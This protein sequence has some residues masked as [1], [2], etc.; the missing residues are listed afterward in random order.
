MSDWDASAAEWDQDLAA[1]QYSRAAFASLQEVLAGAQLTLQGAGVI[2]FGCG[3]GLLTEQLVEAGAERVIAVDTSPAM[4]AVLDAKVLDRG[5]TGVA[6]SSGLPD[7]DIGC[8]LIVCS[9]VC[10]FLDDYPGA[11]VELVDRL[12]PGGL[13]VQWDWERAKGDEHGLTRDEIT[14]ALAAADLVEVDV[15][16]GFESDVDGHVMRPLMGVGLRPE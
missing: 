14:Q 7:V 13:F 15:R 1:R 16:V 9:S 6:T 3:T 12:R 2:D 11:V 4:L 10:A 5:W 8:D